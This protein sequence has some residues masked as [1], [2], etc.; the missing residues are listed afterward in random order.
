M[1]NEARKLIKYENILS[2]QIRLRKWRNR[3]YVKKAENWSDLHVIKWLRG[4]VKSHGH[5]LHIAISATETF[6]LSLLFMFQ[7]KKKNTQM[8]G[9]IRLTSTCTSEG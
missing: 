9:G 5:D 4:N 7:K 3:K 2:L 6:R 1:Q 8:L